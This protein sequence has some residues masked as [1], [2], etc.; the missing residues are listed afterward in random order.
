MPFDAAFF[1]LC[2]R[3]SCLQFA[4]LPICVLSC[5]LLFVRKA[6]ARRILAPRTDGTQEAVR[7]ARKARAV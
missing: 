2:F 5:T 4:P 3:L 7:A 6:V 1:L